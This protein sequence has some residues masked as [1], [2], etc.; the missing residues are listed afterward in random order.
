MT[1]IDKATRTYNIG[2]AKLTEIETTLSTVYKLNLKVSSDTY[3]KL[4][5]YQRQF[6]ID[7]DELE[8]CL[9]IHELMEEPDDETIN[10]VIQAESEVIAAMTDIDE[11]IKL[12]LS[13]K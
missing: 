1:Y 11:L 6:V 7:L 5:T 3:R 10:S 8:L 9:N 4:C 2:L 12:L 13:S